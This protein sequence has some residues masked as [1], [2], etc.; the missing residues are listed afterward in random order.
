MKSIYKLY[1]KNKDLQIFASIFFLVCTINNVN[2]DVSQVTSISEND[3][4]N[5][6]NRNSVQFYEYENPEN[7][8]DDF[9][10]K[11]NDAN[12]TKF[13]TN[14]QDLSLQIDSKNLRDTYKLKLLEMSGKMVIDD[15]NN[16]NFFKSK[17]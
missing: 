3:F 11:N 12:E 9:F 14:Y 10:G 17:I 13:Q 1:F 4:N 15:K 6:V 5:A 16:W 2:A 7:L 8:L